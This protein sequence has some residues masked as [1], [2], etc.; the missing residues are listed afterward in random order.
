MAMDMALDRWGILN[1]IMN[2]AEIGNIII[3]IDC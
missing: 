1:K 2:Y 3:V